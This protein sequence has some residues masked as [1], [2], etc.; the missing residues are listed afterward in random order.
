MKRFFD[1]KKSCVLIAAVM[2]AAVT[3]GCGGKDV[4]KNDDKTVISVGNWPTNPD[5]LNYG[6]YQ[7]YLRLMNETYT[8]IEIVPDSY[9]YST[10]S[11]FVKAASGQ[12]PTVYL[13]WFTE[14]DKIANAGYCADITAQMKNFGFESALN[15]IFKDVLNKDGK[16]YAVPDSAYARGIAVN[17]KL[18]AEAGLLN[19]DG[20]VKAPDTYEELVEYAGKI[21][22]KTGKAGFELAT[23]KNNGGWH[24]MNIAWSYGVEF[25]KSDKDGKWTAAFD[26]PE[27]AAAL[28]YVKDLKWKYDVLPSNSLIDLS[29]LKKLFA[30][31]EAA[32]CFMQPPATELCIN[33]GMNKDDIAFISVPKG[34]KGRYSLM[35][36]NVYMLSN[37]ATDEQKDAV[38]KWLEVM[39]KSP[40][41]TD[42]Q[43]EAWK[44]T[45]EGYASNGG[46]VLGEDAFK[47]WINSEYQEKQ[48]EVLSPY[49]NVDLADYSNY[50]EFKDVIIQPEEP[51]SCQQLY[52]ILDA[53][54]QEVLTNENADV[55]ALV[56][57]AAEDFQ[58]NYLDKLQ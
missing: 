43:I 27:C 1:N 10:D 36:G 51:Q 15:P 34:P 29:E 33:Y 53:C 31:G 7:D 57:Q 40:K 44:S 30:N 50:F 49:V 55:N 41:V 17:K 11:F 19:S 24:F 25:M 48:K 14:V 12:L 18:F 20:T 46:I 2:A 28:Q 6:P 35:G 22:S 37:Q 8:N 47:L 23:A 13:T 45:A 9:K 16:Y 3:A 21:K 58:K 4:T 56:K 38:F 26:T 5:D 39:G 42:K 32:M 52:S 54:I